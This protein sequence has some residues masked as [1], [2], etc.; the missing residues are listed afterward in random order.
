MN[1]SM[2]E[3]IVNSVD[4]PLYITNPT[5]KIL[6]VNPAFSKITGYQS[7]EI[8]GKETSIMKS[9]MMDESYY[10]RLWETILKG[11][12]WREKIINK[13]KDGTIYVVLQSISPI[14][15]ANDEIIYFSAIQYDI[16]KEKEL[17]DERKIFFDVS[18]DLLCIFD[19]QG[20][21]KQLNP[22]W[23]RILG[24]EEKD[25]DK[26]SIYD[27]IYKQD[28]KDFTKTIN[29]LKESIQ[30]VSL[31]NRIQTPNGDYLWVSWRVYYDYEKNLFYASGRDIHE[32]VKME[33]RLRELSVTDVLTGLYNRLKFNEEMERE[34]SRSK[35]YKLPLALIMFDIDHFKN[36]N[37]T[38]GHQIGD[39]V[40]K[41][42]SNLVSKIIRNSDILARWGGEEFMILC[43]HT[44][45]QDMKILAERLRRKIEEYPFSHG[46]KVTISIGA[47]IYS[48]SKDN[49][50]ELLKRVDKAL[51][52]AKKNGRNIVKSLYK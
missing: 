31:D 15:D 46:D 52:E 51:Y 9:G 22:S 48:H 16:T 40:L 6:Y 41:E 19:N 23:K 21:F 38:Y 35:R 3:K 25:L 47:S 5:G 24:W 1:D 49:A 43:P 11:E 28:R 7:E 34:I 10:K 26:E 50:D 27:I 17:E 30:I 44:N 18:G 14:K 12:I 36:I 20:N 37:D 45:N 32:R 39:D 2:F 29:K 42:V 4:S 13:R 8:C 33:E